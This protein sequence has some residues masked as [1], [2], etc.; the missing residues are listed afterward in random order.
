MINHATGT[1]GGNG[2]GY[3]LLGKKVE[4]LEETRFCGNTAIEQLVGE[5]VVIVGNLLEVIS[6][7]ID[8]PE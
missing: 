4:K 8:L 5:L 2:T 6:R 1:R 3:V 7:A